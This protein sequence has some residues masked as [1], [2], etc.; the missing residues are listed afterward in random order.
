MLTIAIPGIRPSLWPDVLNS[1]KLSC[2]KHEYE[3]IFIGP[4]GLDRPFEDNIS[5]LRDYA[6]PNICQHKALLSAKGDILHVFSDDCVFEEDAI[7]LSLDAL[8]GYDAVVTN[9][10]EAG[11]EAVQNFSLNRCY[12]RTSVPENF[13]IFNTAFMRADKYYS[14]GGFDCNFQTLCVAQADLAARWQYSGYNVKVENI[15]LSACGHMPN[16]TGDHGPM[17]WAQLLDDEPLYREK[18]RSVPPLV[19]KL[20]NWETQPKVWE[21]RFDIDNCSDD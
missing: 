10:G 5:F 6:S 17:H 3:V 15:R 9:Y 7:D 21:K 18:Y 8:E 1:I 2:K 4:V 19:L 13:V 12:P 11:N 20:N 16:T 14:L